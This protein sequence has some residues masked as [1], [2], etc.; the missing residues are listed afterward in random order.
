MGVDVCV[1]VKI[2]NKKRKFMLIYGERKS[3]L[4]KHAVSC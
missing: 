3:V 1:C 2:N 4:V